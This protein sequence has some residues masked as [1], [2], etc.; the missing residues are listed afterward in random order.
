MN[1]AQGWQPLQEPKN[2]KNAAVRLSPFTRLAR[3]H[4][5]GSAADGI[6]AVA[7]AG[8]IFFSIDPSAARWR[9][10]LYLLCTITPFAI[11]TPLIGPAIDRL[12]GGRRSMI[13]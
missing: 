12:K 13:V 1:S 6:V 2:L 8:S 7:L 4:A 11:V 3:T 5:L 9:V 10:G